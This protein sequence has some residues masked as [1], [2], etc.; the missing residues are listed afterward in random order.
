M[1]SECVHHSRRLRCGLRPS[2]SVVLM[3]RVPKLR[4]PRLPAPSRVP[5]P[6]QIQVVQAEWWDRE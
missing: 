2:S 5:L 3:L 4:V 1:F 6:S